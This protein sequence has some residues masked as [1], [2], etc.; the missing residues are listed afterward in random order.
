[1]VDFIHPLRRFAPRPTCLRG[2]VEYRVQSADY[3]LQMKGE[4]LLVRGEE[5]NENDEKTKTI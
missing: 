2:T 5:R 4:R 3:R 1:M